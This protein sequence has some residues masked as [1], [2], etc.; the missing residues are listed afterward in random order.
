MD[1]DRIKKLAE[2]CCCMTEAETPCHNED[3]EKCKT[4]VAPMW[5][6][7]NRP[8]IQEMVKKLWKESAD[9]RKENH[10]H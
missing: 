9:A 6:L 8:E 7:C 4:C 5:C 1:T 3:M 10:G 2:W